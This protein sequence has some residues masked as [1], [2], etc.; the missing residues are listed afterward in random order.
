MLKF[1]AKAKTS[2]FFISATTGFAVAAVNFHSLNPN[3]SAFSDDSILLPSTLPGKIKAGVNAVLR[4]SRAVSTIALNV[5][6]YKYSLRGLTLKSEEYRQTLS[7]VWPFVFSN[8]TWIY[9]LICDSF[10]ALSIWNGWN[11]MISRC[12]TLW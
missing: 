10:L 11:A 7:E 5:V 6:D 3:F 4:T 12:Y 2:F 1:P 9:D 8:M